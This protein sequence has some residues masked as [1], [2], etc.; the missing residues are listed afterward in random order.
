VYVVCGGDSISP[1]LYICVYIVTGLVLAAR[2]QMSKNGT[3]SWIGGDRVTSPYAFCR[4]NTSL[5]RRTPSLPTDDRRLDRVGS[6]GC[7]S[8]GDWAREAV[9]SQPKL[10]I[11]RE[12]P[13]AC[14]SSTSFAHPIQSH[15]ASGGSWASANALKDELQ[16]ERQ[17]REAS[18][19]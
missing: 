16:W 17:H 3:R 7:S 11:I 6:T 18:G 2:S 5:R 14:D 10:P 4:S 13:Y 9:R 19:A 12:Y 8:G 1:L 15:L